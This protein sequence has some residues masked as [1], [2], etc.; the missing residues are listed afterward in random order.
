MF[1]TSFA[2]RLGDGEAWSTPVPAARLGPTP[3][4]SPP[5]M[6]RDSTLSLEPAG[7]ERHSSARGWLPAEIGDH[8]RLQYFDRLVDALVV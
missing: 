7:R 5:G 2:T 6:D 8:G 1:G 4:T 3:C